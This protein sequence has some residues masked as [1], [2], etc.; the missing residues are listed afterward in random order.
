[1]VATVHLH[2]LHHTLDPLGI[3][4]AGVAIAAVVVLVCLLASRLI[5]RRPPAAASE[6]GAPTEPGTLDG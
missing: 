3:V 2:V 4:L 1:V 5:R 6:P